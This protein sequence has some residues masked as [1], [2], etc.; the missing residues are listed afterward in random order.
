MK[1][2]A[3]IV[4]NARVEV[5]KKQIAEIKYGLL[6]L[7]SFTHTDTIEDVNYL[8]DRVLKMRIFPDQSDKTNLSILNINGAILSVSQFTLY[9][10]LKSRRPSFTNVLPGAESEALYAAFNARLAEEVTVATGEFG[11]KMLLTFTNVGP[12]TYIL[13]SNER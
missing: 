11:A 8:A 7:V 4:Q 13:D 6:L 5:A 1:I 3:Q 12:V 9:G 2:V 10:D